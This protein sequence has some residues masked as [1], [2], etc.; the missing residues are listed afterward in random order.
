VAAA[1]VDALAAAGDRPV[2]VEREER[3]A[4]VGESAGA[5]A[6]RLASLQAPDFALPDLD[7]RVHSLAEHRGEKVLLIAYAS[8]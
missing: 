7:G 3:V 4:F 8:W 5:R 6:A 2:A 1:P